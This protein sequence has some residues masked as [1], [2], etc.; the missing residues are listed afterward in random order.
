[1]VFVQR[2]IIG[3]VIFISR[4]TAADPKLADAVQKE[5]HCVFKDDISQGHFLRITVNWEF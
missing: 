3:I 2:I 5:L 1:M 4:Y